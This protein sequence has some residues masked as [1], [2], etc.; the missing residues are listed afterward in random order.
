[1]VGTARRES[2]AYRVRHVTN[3]NVCESLDSVIF[4]LIALIGEETR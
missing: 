1:M 3:Q 2:L 4:G